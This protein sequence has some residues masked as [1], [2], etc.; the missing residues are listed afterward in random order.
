MGISVGPGEPRWREGAEY[1][2]VQIFGTEPSLSDF[3]FDFGRKRRFAGTG[4]ARKPEHRCGIRL[5][6]HCLD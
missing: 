2:T 6:R 1:V 4:E 3:L 5:I